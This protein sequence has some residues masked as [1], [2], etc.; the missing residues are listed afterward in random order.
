MWQVSVWVST[1]FVGPDSKL[2]TRSY[3]LRSSCSK[4][5]GCNG[6][7]CLYQRSAPGTR[8]RNEVVSRCVRSRGVIVAGSATRQNK[9]ACGYISARTSITCSPPPWLTNQ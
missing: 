4:A 2:M 8:W 6:R 7:K 9:S 3:P 1:P 5:N